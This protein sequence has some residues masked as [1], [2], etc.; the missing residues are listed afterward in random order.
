VEFG[1]DTLNL[2]YDNFRRAS[3]AFI[4]LEAVVSLSILSLIVAGIMTGAIVILEI[5]NYVADVGAAHDKADQVFSMLK[6][7]A[8]FCGYGMPASA[9]LYRE[10]FANVSGKEPFNWDGVIS[11]SDTKMNDGGGYRKNGTCRI[12]YAVPNGARVLE[13]T[14]ISEDK[15]QL[16]AYGD[17]TILEYLEPTIL[18]NEG[19]KESPKYKEP[20]S[21]KNWILFSSSLP[22]RRPMWVLEKTGY[23][24]IKKLTLKWNKAVSQDALINIHRNDALCYM[25][26]I[27]CEVNTSKGDTVF[28]IKNLRGGGRQPK[29]D[30]VID[31]RFSLDADRKMLYALL[32]VRGDR[33]YE[34]IK[35]K[36][37]PSGWPPEYAADIPENARHYRL[38]TFAESFELKNL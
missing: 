22:I 18:P 6:Y 37:I 38:F 11:I 12:V 16:R 32:L 13:D 1:G 10:A 5:G 28:Y 21:V 29:E 14:V 7:P 35:T 31:V 15:F 19:S 34:E 25:D 4:L 3:G 9:A 2:N 23:S 26:A 27:E 17:K 36:G 30:G 24:R 20:K 8:D 33:R